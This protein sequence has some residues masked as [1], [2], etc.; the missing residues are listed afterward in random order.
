VPRDLVQRD[1]AGSLSPAAAA[2]IVFIAAGAVLMLEI[3]AAR[4]MAPYVG[5]SLNTYT[6]IIGTVLGGIALGAWIGGR[7]AD[8][9]SPPRL[10]GPILIV[11]GLLVMIS[12]PLVTLFGDHLHAASL[13]AIIALSAATVLLPAL[14]LS[15]VTPVVVK[16]QLRDLAAT[17]RVVGR[18]SGFATAGALVGTFGT[19]FILAERVHTRVLTTTI[20]AVLVVLGGIV[21]WRL[22]HRVAPVA[23]IAVVGAVFTAAAAAAAVHGPCKVESGYFCIWVQSDSPG[24]FHRRLILD[25]LTHS[26]V[27]VRDPR[28]LGLP[29]VRV[30]AAAVA[31][32]TTPQQ[33]LAA[34][35][36][37]GGA[38]ALPRYVAATRPRS[39][40]KVIEIDPAVVDTA[41]ADF[42]LRTGP[43]LQAV[44]GDARVLIRKE[45]ARSYDVVVGDAFSSRSPPWHLTTR[46]FL[47]QV[48]HVLRPRGTYLM[49]VIDVGSRFVRAEAATLQRVFPHVVLLELPGSG[50]HV[51]VAAANPIDV[52]GIGAASAKLGVPVR[53]VA[54]QTLRRLVSG[55]PVL[56]DD[57]APVDQLLK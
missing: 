7:A 46:Q 21:A 52:S 45:R 25:D 23:V 24:E 54:G 48:R 34:L 40:D 53:A 36:I 35:H 56:D 6:G 1:R 49:N 26:Y 28:Y 31:A 51:L 12:A 39:V 57:F 41:R 18:L 47:A 19:G 29:Y 17:G 43:R 3:L 9:V 14:V 16:M 55:A 37:G 32:R 2:F 44:V 42:G 30:L 15:A 11:G 5:V 38:F 10:I 20:G 8:R 13:K 50:N 22:V 4:L 27:D 33:A